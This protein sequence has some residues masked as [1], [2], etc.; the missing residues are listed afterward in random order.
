MAGPILPT[1]LAP[2][3]RTIRQFHPDNIRNKDKSSLRC[4][5]CSAIKADQRPSRI[6]T[7]T[8]SPGSLSKEKALST[9]LQDLTSIAGAFI[10]KD[11]KT[12]FK[13]CNFNFIPNEQLKHSVHP[14]PVNLWKDKN[15]FLK[16]F[17]EIRKRN[18]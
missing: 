1:V 2:A 12:L 10:M 8:C 9:P 3:L 11:K 16:L 15:N 17:D 6:S 7:F 14:E 13:L 5:K 18:F 4:F